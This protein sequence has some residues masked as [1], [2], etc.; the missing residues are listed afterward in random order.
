MTKSQCWLLAVAAVIS[1]VLLAIALFAPSHGQIKSSTSPS[2]SASSG[3]VQFPKPWTILNPSNGRRTVLTFPAEY[4]VR[5]SAG[6]PGEL[7]FALVMRGAGAERMSDDRLVVSADLSV[8]AASAE[9]W[10]RAVPLPLS[11]TSIAPYSPRVGAVNPTSVTFHGKIFQGS[12]PIVRF[13]LPSPDE[14][15]L[16]LLGTRGQRTLVEWVLNRFPSKVPG[17]FE[18]GSGDF[19]AGEIYLDVYDVESGLRVVSERIP[20]SRS[21]GGDHSGAASWAGTRYFILPF[22]DWR[23]KCLLVKFPAR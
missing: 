16:A 8:R 1:G 20:F 11:T 18:F 15:W 19:S 7:L 13:A 5:S 2:T 4:A 10:A 17:M 23:T 14:K 3:W 22:H 12:G 21:D 9:E 6:S